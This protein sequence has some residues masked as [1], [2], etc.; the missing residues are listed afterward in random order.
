MENTV[1]SQTLKCPL[2]LTILLP[3]TVSHYLVWVNNTVL[4]LCN[5]FSS[6]I[7]LQIFRLISSA[8]YFE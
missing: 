8:G 6:F 2:V 1:K 4:C 7:Y 3:I 5:I